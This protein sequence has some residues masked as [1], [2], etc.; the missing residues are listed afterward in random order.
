[1]VI[2]MGLKYIYTNRV[3]AHSGTLVRFSVISLGF[4]HAIFKNS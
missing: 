2:S 3:K 1:M 4:L